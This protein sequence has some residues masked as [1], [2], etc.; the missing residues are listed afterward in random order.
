[1]YEAFAVLTALLTFEKD[2]RGRN[3]YFFI[4]NIPALGAIVNGYSSRPALAQLVNAIT[5]VTIR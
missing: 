1:M 2:I 3:V 4:D 5:L